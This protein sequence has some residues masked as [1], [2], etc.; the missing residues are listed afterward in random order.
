MLVN[1]LILKGDEC[2]FKEHCGIAQMGSCH[3]KGVDHPCDFSCASARGFNMI[4]V[5][6]REGA[7][8][9]KTHL[10][11]PSFE[12]RVGVV[13]RAEGDCVWVRLDDTEIIVTRDSVEEFCK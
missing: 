7:I 5:R 13:S 12:G 6:V 10:P 11:R 8:G 9:G 4:L 1:G 3:H 2:P